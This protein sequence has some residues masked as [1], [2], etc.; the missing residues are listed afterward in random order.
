MF[1]KRRISSSISVDGLHEKDL[2]YYFNCCS[3]QQ[4]S[5]PCQGCSFES[6]NY[7][8]YS[9]TYSDISSQN[10]YCPTCSTCLSPS[11]PQGFY[12]TFPPLPG[13]IPFR[14]RPLGSIEKVLEYRPLT[15]PP[16]SV[17]SWSGIE[18]R[19]VEPSIYGPVEYR[20][21]F[22]MESSQR[23]RRKTPT[24]MRR[25]GSYPNSHSERPSTSGGHHGRHRHHHYHHRRRGD[26]EAE[27]ACMMK[28]LQSEIHAELEEQMKEFRRRSKSTTSS[29]KSPD[30]RKRRKSSHSSPPPAP[31][32]S[33][34]SHE[35]RSRSN[36][37][38]GKSHLHK[39]KTVPAHRQHH[40][41]KPPQPILSSTTADPR[42]HLLVQDPS[43]SV[44][45]K[46]SSS[47]AKDIFH[48]HYQTP[49]QQSS[50]P[51]H[52]HPTAAA[53]T[54][55]SLSGHRHKCL[56]DMMP[57]PKE[58]MDRGRYST[59]L[60]SSTPGG[61][62]KKIHVQQEYL[63][64]QPDLGNVE[65]ASRKARSLRSH[66]KS[67]PVSSLHRHHHHGGHHQSIDDEEE[68]DARLREQLEK[69]R[70][71]IQYAQMEKERLQKE[72]EK[73]E[74]EQRRLMDKERQKEREELE[75]KVD[76]DQ[77]EK[78][79]QIE[80][81]RNEQERR[82]I[83]NLKQQEEFERHQQEE[84]DKKTR[85]EK[86]RMGEK[87][88]KGQQRRETLEKLKELRDSASARVDIGAES[89][90]QKESETPL[91]PAIK[92]EQQDSSLPDQSDGGSGTIPK[93]SKEK[94]K[95]D[96]EEILLK[97]KVDNISSELERV[98][99]EK[100]MAE[101]EKV[102]LEMA[103]KQ[104]R[105][106]R[107]RKKTG[108]R[109]SKSGDYNLEADHRTYDTSKEKKSRSLELR[110]SRSESGQRMAVTSPTSIFK[111]RTFSYDDELLQ[112]NTFP[113]NKKKSKTARGGSTA[114]SSPPC[115]CDDSDS[116]NQ[117]TVLEMPVVAGPPP[118]SAPPSWLLD[119]SRRQ[120]SVPHSCQSQGYASLGSSAA[121]Y[122]EG[123]TEDSDDWDDDHR[124]H[125][126]SRSGGGGYSSIKE[127]HS[128]RCASFPIQDGDSDYEIQEHIK[129]CKCSCDHLGYGNYVDYDHQQSTS[130]LMGNGRRDL[131]GGSRTNLRD[132]MRPI[133]FQEQEFTSSCPD[134]I[135]NKFGRFIL[136]TGLKLRRQ[137]WCFLGCIL[138][139]T[140]I[141]ICSLNGFVS[142]S[143]MD[144]SS[145]EMHRQMVVS[146]L[147]E[148]PLI[149]GHND[150]PWNIRKFVHNKL[151]TVN[152]THNLKFIEPWSKS[153]WSHTD[154][155]RMVAGKIGCQLWVAYAPCGAQH[156]DAIQV[157]LEQ[158]DLIKRLSDQYS[159]L[160]LVR[161]S[162][163]L[164]RAHG[165]GKI[166]SLITVE[167]GHSIGTSLAVLRMFHRLGARS[168]TL[169]HNCNTPWADCSKADIPGTIPEH[170]G[171]TQFGRTVVEEMNRLGMI[172]DLSHSSIQTA[173]DTLAVSDA[174]VIFS[175]SSAQALCN[176]TRNIPDNLLRLVAEKKG[177]V[178][179][180]FFSYFLT[181]SNHS[182]VKDVIAHLSHI[183][184]IAGID[185]VGIGASYDGINSTP[186]GLEDVTK[187]PT[188]FASLLATGV[189][190]LE[191]LKKLA[192]LNFLRVFREVE[193]SAIPYK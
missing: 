65:T 40:D 94:M 32:H 184:K 118:P 146:L 172:V 153:K 66:P 106:E 51:S 33:S 149:D 155:S 116:N 180:N 81:E 13:P 178:M 73:K 145:P 27:E 96:L 95:S 135:R 190:S 16:G 192:G 58:E 57:L 72:L 147:K 163:E 150:L 164:I 141:I 77:R 37:G 121:A 159:Q 79:R 60:S 36:T 105:A 20:Q 87:E 136:C 174:P 117:Q 177:L 30:K 143:P 49:L 131:N 169:T 101:K 103:D 55:V 62:R 148:V 46:S 124:R 48:A 126:R 80:I 158:I 69:E 187:Y 84:R 61:S 75:R 191:D 24:S 120:G 108:H 186:S 86:V 123:L 41:H 74:R 22:G 28:E 38:Q 112:I 166:A 119:P 100:E 76:Q 157:T 53:A 165:E 1:N 52:S 45:A 167:S 67:T 168:L 113:M 71:Q 17:S 183:R 161:T 160:K 109:R 129:Y 5:E 10:C 134:F 23:S 44:T 122:I 128:T 6:D 154:I 91:K 142:S 31:R 175:H 144:S 152:F 78:E 29:S 43:H 25:N 83:F 133:S 125:R 93:K 181:C 138:L 2:Y 98:M 3:Q 39:S 12:T 162:D 99:L 14:S 59:Y 35:R 170:N 140:V 111:T 26:E 19:T 188:L 42:Q 50:Q 182:T 15:A 185:H 97:A 130:N 173:R 176:S 4:F 92:M 54:T 47:R 151:D 8:D 102:A 90:C 107:E 64:L 70:R 104:R 115:T 179:V 56:T 189:W 137:H 139:V 132:S 63:Q 89:T 156:K 7:N 11:P 85:R 193:R 88:R 127:R 68:E 171:L 82:E 9:T 18:L 34:S 114:D 110:K 21:L